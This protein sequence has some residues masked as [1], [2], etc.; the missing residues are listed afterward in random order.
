MISPD[1]TL[2]RR[3]LPGLGAAATAVSLL[4]RLEC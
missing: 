3:A 1:I 2:N 4:A